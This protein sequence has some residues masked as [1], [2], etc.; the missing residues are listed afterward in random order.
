MQDRLAIAEDAWDKAIPHDTSESEMFDQ[1]SIDRLKSVRDSA[2]AT[3]LEDNHCEAIQTRAIAAITEAVSSALED[4][5]R[6]EY[7][8]FAALVNR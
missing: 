7:A 8:G 4:S 1:S 5:L 6:D 3:V 2:I